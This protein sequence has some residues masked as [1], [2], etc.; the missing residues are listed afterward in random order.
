MSIFNN[1]HFKTWSMLIR[2]TL[3]IQIEFSRLLRYFEYFY[4]I[5]SLFQK[6]D[7]KVEYEHMFDE[8]WY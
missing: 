2:D 7:V 1:L 6:R 8:K 4:E 5:C 3:N